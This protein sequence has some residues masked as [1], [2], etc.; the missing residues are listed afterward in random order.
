MR[1]ASG[2]LH[3]A[4]ETWAYE[5]L[6]CV[7]N[8]VAFYIVNKNFQSH[9]STYQDRLLDPQSSI[10]MGITSFLKIKR[11]LFHVNIFQFPHLEVISW[12]ILEH[13]ILQLIKA[14]LDVIC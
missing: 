3:S 6:A 8:T 5:K 14:L 9:S 11:L 12:Y 7:K 1:T 13:K 4:L 2:H 10:P